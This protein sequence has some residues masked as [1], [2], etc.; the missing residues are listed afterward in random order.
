MPEG[1]MVLVVTSSKDMTADY[2][3]GRLRTAGIQVVRFNTDIKSSE[4]DI[5]FNGIE[6]SL[7]ISGTT[8]FPNEISHVWLRRPVPFGGEG[9]SGGEQKF[10]AGELTS[11]VEGFFAQIPLRK[12]MNHP[13]KNFLASLKIEQL[14]KAKEFGLEIP[15]TLVTKN[16][17]EF[18]EFWKKCNG[19]VIIKPLSVGYVENEKGSDSLIYTRQILEADL[20]TFEDDFVCPTLFQRLIK[21]KNDIRICWVD[22]KLEGVA[23][24]KVKS[25][26]QQIV[27][28]RRDNMT[29]VVY[30]RLEIPTPVSLALGRLMESYEL[31]FAA[32]DMMEDLEGNWIFLEI[33]PN[34]Q[35]AW[36]DIAGG[37]D[38][39]GLFVQTFKSAK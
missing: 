22:G 39:A 6:T 30:S 1:A 14:A 26:G 36:L 11:A 25:D 3:L 19:S 29:G 7:S 33:N 21:K 15:E 20:D 5:S 10:E 16:K 23:L 31:R 13:T 38:I 28:I 9:D 37:Q 2:L 8:L 34:G 17:I 27:D 32:I 4:I 24:R 18:L 12:W 35:W